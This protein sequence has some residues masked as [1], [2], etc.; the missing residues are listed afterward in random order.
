MALWWSLGESRYCYSSVTSSTAIT[1]ASATCAV[2]QL[3]ETAST[4]TTVSSGNAV[5]SSNTSTDVTLA[6]LVTPPAVGNYVVIFSYV[7]GS[8]TFESKQII[9]VRD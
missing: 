9:T 2:Y 7:I 6:F 3:S 1:I 8:E 5:I 4:V